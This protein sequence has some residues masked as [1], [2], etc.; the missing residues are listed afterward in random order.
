MYIIYIYKNGKLI[1]TNINKYYQ[2]TRK[3]FEKK[4]EKD[5]KIFLK[6]K[7]QNKVEYMR[8]Y[9]LAHKYFLGFCK[10]VGN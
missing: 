3:S 7:N 9:Y 10:V 4:Y 1:L 2:K 8:N 6:K 5:I